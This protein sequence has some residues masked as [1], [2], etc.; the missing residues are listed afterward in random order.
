MITAITGSTG[1]S[2][3]AATAAAAQ[4]GIRELDQ[5]AFLKLLTTQLR[6]QNPL[7]P[8]NGAEFVSQL[9]T[10]SSLQGITNLNTTFTDMLRLQELTQGV[11]LIGQKITFLPPGSS[12]PQTGKV[13]SISIDG[14]QLNLLVNGQNV[15]LSQVTGIL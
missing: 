5:D 12:T 10:F 14:N 7:E 4:T 3:A 11:F 6:F 13:A 1:T 8:Q 9:A 2:A 15:A